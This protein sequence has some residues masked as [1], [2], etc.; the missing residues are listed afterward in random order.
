MEICQSI[1][2]YPKECNSKVVNSKYL[3]N[4]INLQV[5]K[6]YT[7]AC[8]NQPQGSEKALFILFDFPRVIC[9][10]SIEVIGYINLFQELL[11]ESKLFERIPVNF[12]YG[13]QD[14]MDKKGCERLNEKYP[15]RVNFRII[16]SAGHQLNFENPKLVV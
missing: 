4:I 12:Y 9:L 10:N 15:D 1:G 14:W 3:I 7:D 8:I 6:A 2:I 16:E 11:T 5:W 13:R